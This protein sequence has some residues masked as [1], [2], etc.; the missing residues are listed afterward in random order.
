MKRTIEY[1]QQHNLVYTVQE[2]FIE[3][4]VD[5]HKIAELLSGLAK[6]KVEYTQISIDK[7]TLEMYF[8]QVAKQAKE[9]K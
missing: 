6:A 5:E 9:R 7:P 2:R 4:E 8:L 3:L 1:A